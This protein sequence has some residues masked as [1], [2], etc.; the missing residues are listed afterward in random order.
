MHLVEIIAIGAIALAVYLGLLATW[1][2][3][4]DPTLPRTG[5]IVRLVL[6][7]LAPIA[8]PVVILRAASEFAPGSLPSSSLMWPARWLLKVRPRP[9]SPGFEAYVPG[10]GPSSDHTPGGH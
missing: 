3:V 7:W 1:S 6:A 8:G 9:Q 10:E 2:V 4:H 5:R